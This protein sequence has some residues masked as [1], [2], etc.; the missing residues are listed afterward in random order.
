MSTA[1]SLPPRLT[2]VL[3]VRTYELLTS[4]TGNTHTTVVAAFLFRYMLLC[5]YCCVFGEQSNENLSKL[6]RQFP[7]GCCLQLGIFTRATAAAKAALAGA[8]AG[9]RP[10][11][12]SYLLIEVAR[13][14]VSPRLPGDRAFFF[15]YFA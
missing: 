7:C 9:V 2:L 13:R 15:F 12:Y 11:S 1:T 10:H 8:Q 14:H 6:R 5:C 4:E 3:A